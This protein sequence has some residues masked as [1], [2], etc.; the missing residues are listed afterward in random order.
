QWGKATESTISNLSNLA[1]ANVVVIALMGT[2]WFFAER[3]IQRRPSVGESYQRWPAVHRAAALI[4]ATAVSVLAGLMLYS[5]VIPQPLAHVVFM[6]WLGWSAATAFML[7]CTRDSSFRGGVCSLYALGLAAIA[8]FI[9]Q[10]NP[11]P[12]AL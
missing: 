6:N 10:L 4:S 9:A 7:V 3:I 12:L 8:I 2:V 1:N 11:T 5:V